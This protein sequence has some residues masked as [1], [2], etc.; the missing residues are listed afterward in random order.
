MK[1]LLYLRHHVPL[2]EVVG[3]FALH[4]ASTSCPVQTVPAEN[5]LRGS[6]GNSRPTHDACSHGAIGWRGNR[7]QSSSPRLGGLSVKMGAAH[8]WPITRLSPTTPYWE[9]AQVWP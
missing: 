8:G 5:P 7:D 1:K 3:P 2:T 6:R 9:I 4:E